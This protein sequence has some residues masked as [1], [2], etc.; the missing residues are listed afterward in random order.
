MEFFAIA[1]AIGVGGAC[2]LVIGNGT[3]AAIER[4]LAAH[5]MAQNAREAGERIR[6]RIA[7]GEEA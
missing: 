1:V 3:H 5:K 4:R 6:T 7:A 2:A